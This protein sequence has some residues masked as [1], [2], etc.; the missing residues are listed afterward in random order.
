MKQRDLYLGSGFALL[1]A[2]IG[3]LVLIESKT[4]FFYQSFTPEIV[5]YACGYGLRHPGTIP[6]KLLAFLMQ[7]TSSFDCRD[8]VPAGQLGPSGL[9]VQLQIYFSMIVAWV[10]R[11]SSV[12]YH[13]LWVLVCSLTALYAVGC[14][15]LLRQFL[16]RTSAAVG[17]LF[18]TLS[19]VALPLIIMLRDFAKAPFFVWATIFL[20]EAIRAKDLRGLSVYGGASGIIIGFGSG[21]RADL[22]IMLPIGLV[23]LL[24]AFEPRLFARRLVAAGIFLVC[25]LILAYPVLSVAKGGT[26]GSVIIQ[27]MSDPFRSYLKM[28]PAPYSFGPRYSDELV[29]SSIA[30]DEGRDRLDWVENEGAPVYEVSQATT[31]SSRNWMRFAPFFVADFIAQASKSAAWIVGFPAMLTSDRLPDPGYPVMVGPGISLV[32]KGVYKLFAHE[33]MPWL[34]ILGLVLLFWRIWSRSRL[35]ALGISFLFGTLLTYPV[36]QFSV[37]HVFHLEFVWLLSLLTIVE[38]RLFA[39]SLRSSALSYL[40]TLS[41]AVSIAF[42]IYWATVS[43]QEERLTVQFEALLSNPREYVTKVSGR[44]YGPPVVVQLPVP[45]QHQP[46]LQSVPDSMTPKIAAVGI[47]WDVRSAADRI[48]LTF[49]GKA[50]SED[51]VIESRYERT[52]DAWQEMGQSF[53]LEPGE[54]VN[55]TSVLVPAFYRPT[56]YLSGFIISGMLAN[57]QVKIE[58]IGGTTPF[59]ALLSA[60]LPPT[61]RQLPLHIGFGGF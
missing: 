22:L 18:L 33:W 32:F 9:F 60:V 50:C 25:T 47:Q 15:V 49:S 48:L 61:W 20:I 21:F 52:A 38:L 36:V 28:T 19:P 31:E 26:F 43:Y 10:W 17:A 45:P 27:G 55:G 57:C 7:E 56:Q 39:V 41:G 59:P 4:L 51:I 37:R 16:E 13:N 35:E 14:F 40:L 23:T 30:A 53:R 8:L 2:V 12:S 29:L 3:F 42:A 54:P 34:C 6:P 58:R 11:L 44:D 1:G 5:Y 46:L 24:L